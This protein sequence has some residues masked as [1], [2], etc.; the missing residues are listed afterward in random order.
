MSKKFH[1][2]CDMDGCIA[3]F[4]G[5]SVKVIKETWGLELTRNDFKVPRTAEL[6]YNKLLTEEQ[7]K[8]FKTHKDIYP[9]MCPKEFFYNIEPFPGA[10]ETVKRLC[11]K[12][13]VTIITKPLEWVNCPDEKAR[14]LK[15]YLP[16]S[17]YGL[18]M[19]GSMEVKGLV[20]V[21]I[22]VDDDPRALGNI[23]NGIPIAVRQPWN[24]EF[25][26]FEPIRAVDNFS[27][28]EPVIEEAVK[29]LW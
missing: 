10:I 3:N 24:E 8:P 6:L 7:K 22:M 27:E 13:D 14:W 23:K 18:I 9:V 2:G 15:K 21:D 4:C 29:S 25:L 19:T 16:D 26:K 17:E 5:L 1:I 12:Y 28:I 20:D 11:E